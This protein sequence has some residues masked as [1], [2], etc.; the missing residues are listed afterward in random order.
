MIWVIGGTSDAVKIVDTMLPVHHK[1][2]VSTTTGYGSFLAHREGVEVLQKT[3]EEKDM[4]SF[5]KDRQ[6]S[7]IVD[8]SHPFAEIVSK[9][10]IAAAGATNT[11]Y[12]RY[13]RGPVRISG[14]LYY[15][16]YESMV[17]ALLLEQGNILL[18][19]GSKNIYKFARIPKERIVARVLAVKESLE[20]CEK[21]GL[22]P[23]NIIAS[24]G[25]FSQATNQ[26]LM[27]EFQVRHLVT[28]DSGEAGGLI[29]KVS[30]ANFLN[31]KIHILDKP[32]VNFPKVVYSYK[33][34][35]NFLTNE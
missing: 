5:I 22:G 27:Q 12:L 17:S 16:D 26:A 14:A 18:T 30:A 13:E 34:V 33:D 11:P 15:Q 24:K 19:I 21:A 6:I 20:L 25:R 32:K 35:L 7:S 8:A 28:K 29:E 3:M 23:H 31:V 10:A 4:V 1:V 2:I 9:N